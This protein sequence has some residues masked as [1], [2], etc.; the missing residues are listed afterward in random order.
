MF[1]PY[2]VLGIEASATDE[3]VKKAYR[4]LSRKYHP[5]ANINNPNAAAAE[6]K[7]KEVQQAYEQIMRDR[8][9]GIRGDAYGSGSCGPGSSRYSGYSQSSYD[10]DRQYREE[11][12]PFGFGGFGFGFGPFGY[13]AYSR[14]EQQENDRFRGFSEEETNRLKAAVS[15][16]NAGHYQEAWNA[17]QSVQNRQALW[18][19]LAAAAADGMGN[20]VTA[21]EYAEKACSLE[22]DNPEYASLLQRLRGGGSWYERR[23]MNFGRGGDERAG[24]CLRTASCCMLLSCCGFGSY[25]PLPLCCCC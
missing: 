15:Y 18:Y 8:E 12:D 2:S 3:E 20:N 5:D 14:Y 24:A 4:S 7:F 11:Y 1:N 22:P 19:Y 16:I 25:G 17:L 21:A 23:G 9:Q 13:G 6:E 10:G